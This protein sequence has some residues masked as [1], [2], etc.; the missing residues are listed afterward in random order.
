MGTIRFLPGGGLRKLY[1][2][3]D[4]E[5]F[6]AVVP[7][8]A[9]FVEPY[10]RGLRLAFH[11]VRRIFGDE[12]PEADWTRRWKCRWRVNL[13]HSGGPIFGPFPS[14]KFALAYEQDWV[15]RNWILK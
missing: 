7:R 4:A 11:L 14:R 5:T 1:E 3:D 15:T 2:D 8:R 13:E 9:S 10:H 12:G 6:G